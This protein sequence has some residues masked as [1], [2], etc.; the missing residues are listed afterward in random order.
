MV[1]DVLLSAIIQA[2]A[3]AAT[4]V[5]TLVGITLWFGGKFSDISSSISSIDKSVDKVEKSVNEVDLKE[6]EKTVLRLEYTL[7][8][9]VEGDNSVEYELPQSEIGV[10]ISLVEDT[11][12][13][14]VRPID[15]IDI[16]RFVDQTVD[17]EEEK[18]EANIDET[19]EEKIEQALKDSEAIRGNPPDDLGLEEEPNLD[20]LELSVV[21][22]ANLPDSEITCLA[23]EFDE[24]IR[25]RAVANRLA[26][27]RGMEKRE[28]D[29]FDYECGF[30]PLSPIEIQF[31]VPTTD[32][33]LV[34][35]WLD[36]ILDKIDEYHSEFVKEA[37]DFD[38]EVESTLKE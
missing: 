34:A 18:T 6:I 22:E 5:V 35:E 28:L 13:G 30:D 3:L 21:R 2:V 4:L 24:R 12:D 8:D 32:Y 19:V 36:I 20:E 25:S 9:E 31:A 26:S 37:E 33:E 10:T 7:G 1:S 14:S 27:D 38:N 11:D 15:H 17:T 23:I 29:M 16:E